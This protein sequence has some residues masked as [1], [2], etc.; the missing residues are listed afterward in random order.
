MELIVVTFLNREWELFML[1]AFG[2]KSLRHKTRDG[3]HKIKMSKKLKN[4]LFKIKWQ[5]KKTE[6]LK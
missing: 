2:H 3:E 4:I 5:E 1:L 6:N